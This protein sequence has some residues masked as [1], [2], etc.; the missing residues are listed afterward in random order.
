MSLTITVK[1]LSSETP[2]QSN[3]KSIERLV[4]RGE[5]IV[6]GTPVNLDTR[7][8]TELSKELIR[9]YDSPFDGYAVRKGAASVIARVAAANPAVCELVILSAESY[10][11]SQHIDD[12]FPY[13]PNSFEILG[14]IA[15]GKKR[16]RDFLVHV[17]ANDFEIPKY[18]AEAALS[19]FA[20]PGE[21]AALM[22]YAS[23]AA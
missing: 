6:A 2:A 11:K 16:V 21:L 22:Q 15:R 23:C 8:V 13:S 10:A 5:E 20:D 14:T 17:A 1:G 7:V 19:A 18:E 12:A 4:G 9:I 3:E